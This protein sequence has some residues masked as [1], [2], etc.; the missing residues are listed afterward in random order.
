MLVSGSGDY[1][2]RIWDAV[3]GSE[4]YA[5]LLANRELE[6]EVSAQVLELHSTADGDRVAVAQAIRR[7]FGSDAARRRAALKVLARME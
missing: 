6:R 1:A 5:Q 4:R 7:R 2:V 3:P